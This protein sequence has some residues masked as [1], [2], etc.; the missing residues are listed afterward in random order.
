MV[1]SSFSIIGFLD[2]NEW[3]KYS[4]FLNRGGEIRRTRQGLN[5]DI[6]HYVNGLYVAVPGDNLPEE[7]LCCVT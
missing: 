1:S 3:Q 7:I 2:V 6:T 4:N 5:M